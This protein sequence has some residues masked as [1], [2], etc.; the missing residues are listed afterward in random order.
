MEDRGEDDLKQIFILLPQGM[1]YTLSFGGT[2]FAC[3]PPPCG[4]FRP[5]AGSYKL[6]ITYLT[7]LCKN[8]RSRMLSCD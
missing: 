8:F 4:P 7:N 2:A 6:S 1:S 3:P 5:K